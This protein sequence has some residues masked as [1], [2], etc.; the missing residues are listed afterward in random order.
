MSWDMQSLTWYPNGSALTSAV[1]TTPITPDLRRCVWRR[2]SHRC[3]SLLAHSH[4]HRRRTA[5]A[6]ALAAGVSCLVDG[7]FF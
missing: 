5:D 4:R 2:K 7:S 3:H 6:Q 1:T